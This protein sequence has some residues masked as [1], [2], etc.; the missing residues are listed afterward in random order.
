MTVVPPIGG[1]ESSQ[2]HGDRK[3]RVGAGGR[4]PGEGRGEWN[5]DSVSFARGR[6]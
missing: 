1:P 2:I 6:R 3:R 5:G 4:G